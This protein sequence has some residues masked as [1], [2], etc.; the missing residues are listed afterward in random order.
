[1]KKVIVGLAL[2]A[3]LVYLVSKGR[4]REGMIFAGPHC[5]DQ[6]INC[7]EADPTGV[8]TKC[9]YDPADTNTPDSSRKYVAPYGKPN[10]NYTP[11]G[12]LSSASGGIGAIGCQINPGE[13][14]DKYMARVGNARALG[15]KGDS[16]V[17]NCSRGG[18]GDGTDCYYRCSFRSPSN[19]R[20]D[21]ETSSPWGDIAGNCIVR[22]RIWAP[23]GYVE[24]NCKNG[25]KPVI[26]SSKY[27]DR[28]GCGGE[29]ITKGREFDT[30]ICACQMTGAEM[31]RLVQKK[32][33]DPNNTETAGYTF[34][35]STVDE[36]PPVD[37]AA[38]TL[39]GPIRYSQAYTDCQTWNC[40]GEYGECPV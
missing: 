13:S 10:Q 27:V 14:V 30:Y 40:G 15:A 2:V 19:S 7:A 12:Q 28:Q 26:R 20:D 32:T 38:V 8:C 3:V 4:R 36:L 1:M 33:T 24:N 29:K 18:C 11:K 9:L 25:F 22:G 23:E 21:W 39:A 16:D 5:A 37:A 6:R 17:Y 34:D 35:W 31:N